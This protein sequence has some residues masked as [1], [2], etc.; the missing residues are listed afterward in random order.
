VDFE[1]FRL[2]TYY[3][4]RILAR[5]DVLRPIGNIAASH[6]EH[7]DGSGYHRG[8]AASQMTMTARVVAAA[9]AYVEASESESA[10]DTELTLSTLRSRGTLDPDCLSGLAAEIGS[11]KSFEPRKRAWPA[12]LTEREVEVL[13]LVASGCSLKETAQQLVIS[14]HTAR[15]HLESVYSKAGVSSRAGVTLFA[16]ENGLLA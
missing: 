2:H 8:L 16:V 7:L 11:D 13:R 14:D 4:E 5:S 6:H 10:S 1:H 3:T 9:S 12:D 15:H